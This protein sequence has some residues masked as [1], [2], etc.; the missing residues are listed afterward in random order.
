MILAIDFDGTIH[1]IKHP[2]KGRRMG[3]P[4]KGAQETLSRFKEEGHTIIVHSVRGDDPRHVIKDWMDF[5]KVP[6]DSITNIKP[7]AD[8]YIDDKGLRFRSW[9]NIP[10]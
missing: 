8:F 6:Y 3:P 10:L 5:Y 9:D 1:D 7:Q 2:I 4:I